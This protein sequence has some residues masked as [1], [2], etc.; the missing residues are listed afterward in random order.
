[1]HGSAILALLEQLAAILSYHVV[2]GRLLVN[3]L[4]DGPLKTLGGGTITVSHDGDKV[5][6]T[7]SRGTKATIVRPDLTATNGVVHVI[8]GVLEPPK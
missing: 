6:L 8:D 7:G 1:M 3:D 2:R 4:K 5:V